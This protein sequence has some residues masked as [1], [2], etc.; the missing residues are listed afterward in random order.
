MMWQFVWIDG[1]AQ[2]SLY[3]RT[4]IQKGQNNEILPAGQSV[5][6]K[7]SLTTAAMRGQAK[8]LEL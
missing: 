7:L 2:D 5:E 1:Y 4:K 6:S 3:S 8:V